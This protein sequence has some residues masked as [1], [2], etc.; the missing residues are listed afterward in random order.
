MSLKMNFSFCTC[1]AL[2]VPDGP[3]HSNQ[4]LIK[5]VSIFNGES[6]ELITG[7]DVV[8]EGHKIHSLILAESADKDGYDAVI[9]GK[10]GYLTPGLIDIH[11][12]TMFSL[13][14]PVIVNKSK[15]YVAAVACVE[16]KKLLMRGVTTVRD[17]AGDV[18]GI[19]QA[20]DE[21]IIEGPRIYGSGAILS[22]YSGHGDFRNVNEVSI[23][24]RTRMS[25]LLLKRS[26]SY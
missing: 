3:R 8:L 20:I 5:N 4:K 18:F 19:Q 26:R 1:D 6:E 17:A 7:Y 25:P 9:D 11:W 12:H 21:G 13:H 10:G 15:A 2:L 14:M 16:S 23:K 22:Q 24:F